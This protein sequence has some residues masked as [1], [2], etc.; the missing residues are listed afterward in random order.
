MV[1]VDTSSLIAFL[2]RDN[3]KRD[4]DKDVALID[5]A[6]S[7]KRLIIPQVVQTEILSN[8]RLDMQQIVW[9]ENLPTLEIMTGFWQRAGL[10]RAKL[11]K[12]RLKARLADTLIA[13]HCLDH[14]LPLISRDADF[15]HY[16]PF[17]LTLAA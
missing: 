16:V 1:A 3:L 7:E 11:L 13:Q 12:K 10:L 9:L 15:R 6:L 2:D 8:P 5:T 4:H 14:D 17:G